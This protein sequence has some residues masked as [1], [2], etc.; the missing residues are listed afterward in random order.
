[1][2]KTRSRTLSLLL[3][4]ILLAAGCGLAALAIRYGDEAHEVLVGELGWL[5]ILLVVGVIQLCF[6]LFDLYDLH[7]IRQRS[8]LFVRVLEALGLTSIALATVF[9]A[10]PRLTIGRGVFLLTIL[11]TLT[12]MMCWRLFAMWALGH[13]RMAE[14]VLILGTGRHAVELAREVLDQRNSGYKIIG[15]V[16]DDPSLLGKSLINPS[17]IGLTSDL[18][19]VVRAS[20]AD[21]IVVAVEDRRGHLPIDALM[22]LTLPD[23]VVVEESVAFFEQLTGKVNLEQVRP[24]WLIFRNG[25]RWI[26]IYK[27]AWRLVDIALASIGLVLSAPVMLATAIA[28]K[29]DSKGPVIYSQ[30][31][32]GKGNK[33]FMIH[34]F[35][36]MRTDAEKNGAVWAIEADDRV[37]RVGRIIRKLRI[38][39][40]PQF[41]NVLKGDMSFIGPRPE[42]PIFVEMLEREIKYYSQRHLIKPGLTGWAQVRYRYGASVE[43]AR[44]KFQYDLYYIK[45]QSPLLDAIILFETIRIC[46]F[47]RG[48]R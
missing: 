25:S 35:R 22:K 45:N 23:E 1:M 11:L 16:G 47:G 26:R 48:A 19:A 13:P 8:V 12:M 20:R 46:L 37:T 28:I 34:K 6:Y 39:E 42:R 41:V 7:M 43:D 17:V 15:F 44:E 31:R 14:R 21:R 10:V 32:V 5:K 9:Y 30:E 24:S 3:V 38:D 33:P 2:S 27:H 36:S 40:L 4:E 18:E 29:L